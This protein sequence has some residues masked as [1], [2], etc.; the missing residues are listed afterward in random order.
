MKTASSVF[1]GT[2]ARQFRIN[3]PTLIGRILGEQL[4]RD[5]GH[6]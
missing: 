3:P 6:T 2:S 1:G 4:F 5:T